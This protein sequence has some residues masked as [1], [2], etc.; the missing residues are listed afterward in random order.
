ME[1]G[2]F[3]RAYSP[4][5]RFDLSFYAVFYTYFECKFPLFTFFYTFTLISFLLLH[6]L[7]NF[8]L[9]SPVRNTELSISKQAKRATT[10]TLQPRP[11]KP[12]TAAGKS[13]GN[14]TVLPLLDL[15]I[16]CN[17]FTYF[18]PSKYTT[19]ISLSPMACDT[20]SMAR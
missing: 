15:E 8:S 20:I 19:G 9:E 10:K 18:S 13:A 16:S 11:I 14:T 12:F 5:P 4:E 7:F 2:C 3:F 17:D 1:S 6:I